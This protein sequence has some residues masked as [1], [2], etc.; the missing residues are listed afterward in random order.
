MGSAPD[1]PEYPDPAETAAAQGTINRE[2]A[3][4]QAYLNNVNQIT[5]YGN[6]TYEV[7]GEADDGTPLFQATTELSPAQ[8]EL[9]GLQEQFGSQA[10]QIAVNQAGVIGDVLGT[11]VDLSDPAIGREIAERYYPTLDR[12]WDQNYDTFSA[13]L[14]NQGIAVG[15][16]AY[17]DAL[18]DF[19]LA[20]TDAYNATDL[21]ARGQAINELLQERNQPINETT[22]LLGAT[23]VTNPN[24][25]NTPV[26]GV[27]GVDYAGLV[28]QAYN[29]DYNNYA[30][31]VN[32][33][34]SFWGSIA[35]LGGT[36]LGG[37]ARGGFAL[38]SDR[39]LKR[40][41]SRV[42]A[43]DD[44]TPI[45]VYQ[46]AQGGP[47]MMGVMADEVEDRHPRAVYERP[48]GMK[49]V[50]YGALASHAADQ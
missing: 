50:D 43:M 19:E 21:A 48:D 42:G 14:A 30:T 26:T 20:R 8:Q 15:S 35:G 34:N 22:A 36:A 28:D 31:A 1:P 39:R 40:N 18:R 5:P 25:V 41:V 33:G 27:E 2:T 7:Y 49:L 24:F 44:G 37:W 11:P 46:Y 9:L 13:N 23:Q 16:D 29:A 3:I 17:T 38:P 47:F 10:G 6:L 4:T 32:Q 12:R 45:Y